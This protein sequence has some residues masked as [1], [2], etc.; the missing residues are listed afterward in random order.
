MDCV[1]YREAEIIYKIYGF[2]ERSEQENR[3]KINRGIRY[4]EI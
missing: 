4:T 2:R 1:A 3:S